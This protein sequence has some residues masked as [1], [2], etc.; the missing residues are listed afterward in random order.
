MW[1]YKNYS[2]LLQSPKLSLLHTSK[3]PIWRARNNNQPQVSSWKAEPHIHRQQQRPSLKALPAYRE[4]SMIWRRHM[5]I[6]VDTV[7]NFA[8]R[9]SLHSSRY[10]N[11]QNSTTYAPRSFSAWYYCI[12]KEHQKECQVQDA[13]HFL[14]SSWLSSGPGWCRNSSL[15]GLHN[16]GVSILYCHGHPS[17]PQFLPEMRQFI[18][19][20]PSNFGTCKKCHE[21]WT[22]FVFIHYKFVQLDLEVKFHFSFEGNKI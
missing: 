16:P 22:T 15:A 7:C 10:G 3:A 17:M 11:E 2:K 20:W 4:L 18:S 5:P 14:I 8:E 12:P 1:W 21:S 6:S 9:A 19:V 13:H